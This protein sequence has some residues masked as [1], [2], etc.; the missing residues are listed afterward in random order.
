[1]KRE[2][3]KRLTEDYVRA[4]QNYNVYLNEFFTTTLNGV[5]QS[6]A[7]KVFTSEELMKIKQLQLELD[8]LRQKWFS[9]IGGQEKLED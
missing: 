3:F 7:S 9:V 1:M 6:T 4:E 2:E 8:V 5:T